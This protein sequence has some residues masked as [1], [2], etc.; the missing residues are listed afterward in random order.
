M[1]PLYYFGTIIALAAAAWSVYLLATADYS[2]LKKIKI[3]M[4]KISIP[5]ATP[6]SALKTGIVLILLM[7]LFPPYSGT[8]VR[9]GDNLHAFVGYY[10]VFLE[11]P[12]KHVL[13]IGFQGRDEHPLFV[14]AHIDFDR[15]LVQIITVALVTGLAYLRAKDR[16]P[17]PTPCSISDS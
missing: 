3:P 5:L 1:N 13:N 4:P 11:P 10:P 7:G 17:R 6:D 16:E 14:N 8:I 9:S 15:F 12:V 2:A